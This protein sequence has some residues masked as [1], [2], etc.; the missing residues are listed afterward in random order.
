MP[1]P[2]SPAAR[3]PSWWEWVGFALLALLVVAFGFETVRRSSR[4]DNRTTDFTVYARAAWAVRTGGNPY[5]VVDEHGWHYTYPPPFVLFVTPLADPP[6]GADRTGYP[7]FA[8]SVAVWYALNVLFTAL[9]VH[10]F[11]LALLPDARP[12]SRRWWYA[13][14]LP[15]VVCLTSVG[16]SLGRGQANPLVLALLAGGFLLAVRRR[17]VWAGVL[18]AAAACVKVIPGL[19]VLFPLVRGRWKE[20]LGMAAGG[21]LLLGVLPAAVWGPQG[22]VDMN[23]AFVSEVVFPGLTNQGSKS[24]ERELTGTKNTDSQAF[25]AILH[26]IRHPD[27]DTRPT[28]SDGVSKAVHYLLGLGMVA[29]TVWAYLR[30]PARGSA[31]A[32]VLL[33]GCLGAVMIHLAPASHLHFYAFALPLVAGLAAV[34][35]AR[36]PDRAVPTPWVL[37]GLWAWGVGTT[38]PVLEKWDLACVLRDYGLGV[39]ATVGLWGWGVWWLASHRPEGRILSALKGRIR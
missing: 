21:V 27:R 4:P 15:F 29:A 8:V 3:P 14:V 32:G 23:R 33:F 2:A 13:R 17:P 5:E 35:L 24:R 31:G 37:A 22:A 6:D 19:F 1:V 9:A 34:D 11:A 28:N 26:T 39:V 30:S 18:L 16:F 20:L 38:I 10:L 7:P 25:H 12:R 36:H